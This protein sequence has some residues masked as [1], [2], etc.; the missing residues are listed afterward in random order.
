MNTQKKQLRYGP[1]K[2]EWGKQQQPLHI[3]KGPIA[4]MTNDVASEADQATNELES[5]C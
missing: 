1:L 4:Q 2:D 5:L 3:Q